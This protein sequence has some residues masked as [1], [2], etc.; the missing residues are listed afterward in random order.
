MRET[1][2][3]KAQYFPVECPHCHTRGRVRLTKLDK[4]FQCKKCGRSFH[5]DPDKV[6][7]GVR[8]AEHRDFVDDGL[9]KP[10]WLLPDR[11][12]RLY[13]VWLATPGSVR[14]GI[15]GVLFLA[16]AALGAWHSMRASGPELPHSLEGRAQAL[17]QSVVDNNP[18]VAKRIATRGDAE[19]AAEWLSAARSAMGG[20]RAPAAS[21]VQTTIEIKFQ[22]ANAKSGDRIAGVVLAFA[23]RP[24]DGAQ[25]A[26]YEFIS[27]WSQSGDSA[28]EF[29]ADRTM[30]D[31]APH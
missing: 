12:S 28:W 1:Q 21:E 24:A 9:H 25:P 20:A 19:R 14:L 23:T 3:S 31:A 26:T 17:A 30:K 11:A 22:T 27:F 8:E 10:K 6:S 29:D 5:I 16:V 18:D 13:R 2:S 15:A 7:A 4:S